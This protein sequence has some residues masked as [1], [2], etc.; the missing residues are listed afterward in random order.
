[1]RTITEIKSLIND[2][3]NYIKTLEKNYKNELK[4]LEQEYLKAVETINQANQNL[5]VELAEMVLNTDNTPVEIE[6]L[7]TFV[8][9]EFKPG[10][11]QYDYIYNGKYDIKPGDFV[12]VDSFGEIKDVKVL[13][14]FTKSLNNM[15]SW[16]NYKT[17]EDAI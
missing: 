17:A 4:K 12:E 2:N 14:V 5:K 3:N 1:M 16:I 15:P 13:K 8:T 6:N 10:G 7:T 11:K 9:I